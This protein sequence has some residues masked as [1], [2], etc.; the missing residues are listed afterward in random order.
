MQ[1]RG[2]ARTRTVRVVLD[3]PAPAPGEAI[4]AG[5]KSLGTM[6]SSAE[7]AGLAL[8]RIDR[9][10]DALDAGTPLTSG[11]LGLHLAEPGDVR[12]VPKQ[13]VA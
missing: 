7:G 3:G 2:T 1:H 8:I 11:G 5:D 12:S 9:A 6:G 10:A 4:L 13:T